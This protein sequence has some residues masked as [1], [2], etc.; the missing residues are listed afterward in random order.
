MTWDTI[1][2]IALGYLRID[3]WQWPRWTL[4]EFNTAFIGWEQVHIKDEWERARAIAF[5][6]VTPHVKQGT[7]KRWRDIFTIPGEKRK[8]GKRLLIR[9]MDETELQ[10][11]KTLGLKLNGR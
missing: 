1:D 10:E 11:A 8:K 2:Q 6:S 3:P 7:F 5:Y 4:A 9:K